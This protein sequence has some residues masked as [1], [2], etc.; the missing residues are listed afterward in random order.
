MNQADIDAEAQA[1]SRLFYGVNQAEFARRH[2]V[3]GGASMLS[4]HLKGRRPINLEAATVYAR[5]LGVGLEVISPRLAKAA[6]EAAALVS[7]LQSTLVVQE[8]AP[9]YGEW[10][11][12]KHLPYRTWASLDFKDRAALAWEAAQAFDRL[13]RHK[14]TL[15]AKQA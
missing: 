7:P 4:Q 11:F 2:G 13:L 14:Q 15:K 10:P 6:M 1:L 8:P 3:P 5:G 9:Y 12:G